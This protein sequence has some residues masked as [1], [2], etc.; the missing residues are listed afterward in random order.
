MACSSKFVL[1]AA[2][3]VEDEAPLH[4]YSFQFFSKNRTCIRLAK[5]SAGQVMDGNLECLYHGRQFN[6]AG[7]TGSNM[8]VLSQ[9]TPVDPKK[10]PQFEQF[11][12]EGFQET[13][14]IYELPY[15][16]SILLEN[17]MDPAHVPISYMSA[18]VP[19][20]GNK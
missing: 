5:L 13:S 2:A 3:T 9:K 1:D 16:Y 12:R 11:A 19:L 18:M 14:S 8:G 4:H 10:L 7:I 17:L 15:D 20:T 6:G